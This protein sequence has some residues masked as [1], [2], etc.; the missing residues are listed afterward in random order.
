MIS[1]RVKVAKA[2]CRTCREKGLFENPLAV[3]LCS[4]ACLYAY[5]AKLKGE[6]IELDLDKIE[7]EAGVGKA[8][9]SAVLRRVVLCG[10]ARRY[11]VL[12]QVCSRMLEEW[13][14]LLRC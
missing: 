9:A 4:A 13:A 7:R 11:V 10:K 1:C 12:M 2:L 3:R 5:L 8:A 6:Y 14:Y